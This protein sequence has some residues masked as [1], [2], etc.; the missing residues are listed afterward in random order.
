MNGAPSSESFMFLKGVVAY[1]LKSGEASYSN[2]FALSA[3]AATFVASSC[4]ICGRVAGWFLA[5]LSNLLHIYSTHYHMD[6][7]EHIQRLALQS[8]TFHSS[9]D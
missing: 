1:S 7:C 6:F 2:I 8:Q 5:A 3:F 9:N 4:Y